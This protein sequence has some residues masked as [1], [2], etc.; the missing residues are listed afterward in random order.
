[1]MFSGIALDDI[2]I[3]FLNKSQHCSLQVDVAMK[4]GFVL[5]ICM[6]AFLKVVY[7]HEKAIKVSI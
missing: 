7:A 2:I 3:I 6:M 4:G 1:M 5:I